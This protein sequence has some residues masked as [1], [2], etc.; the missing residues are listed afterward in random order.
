MSYARN[1]RRKAIARA[2]KSVFGGVSYQDDIVHPET[3]EVCNYKKI[4]NRWKLF[5]K[6]T[7]ELPDSWTVKAMKMIAK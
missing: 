4:N 5:V 6:D 3:G 2:I 7:G 1:V